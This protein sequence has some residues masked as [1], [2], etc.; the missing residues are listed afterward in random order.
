MR[1]PRREDPAESFGP[2]LIYECLG[3]G[4]MATVHRAKQTGIEGFERPVALKRMLPWLTSDAEFVKSFVREARLAALLRH[5]NIVQTYDLGKVDAIYYIAMELVAGRD[6]RELLRHCH[7][8][9]GPPPAAMTI[10]VLHQVCDALD[11]AHSFR[12]EQGRTLNLV[13]RDISPA[14]IIISEE[15][16]AK[17]VD[18][19]VAKGSTATLATMSGM[20][21]GK[22][23][24]MA[25]EMISGQIDARCD[26]F[27]VGVV[28]WELLTARP[29]FAGGD[30]MEILQRV[31]TWD[32]PAPSSINPAVPR[33]LDA[34]VAMALAKQ[35]QRRFQSAAQMRAGLELAA[36][37]PAMRA[38]SS[39]VAAWTA[40]AFA[41]KQG[42]RPSPPPPVPAPPMAMPM[43]APLAM[44][45]TT[46]PGST[47]APPLAGAIGSAPPMP[48]APVHGQPPAGSAPAT[49][50]GG[51]DSDAITLDDQTN[52][53]SPPVIPARPTPQTIP[54]ARPASGNR[55]PAADVGVITQPGTG[56]VK[57]QAPAGRGRAQAPV[58]NQ[59]A[60][61]IGTA[62]P[63]AV[64]A[65]AA[66][67]RGPSTAPPPP[68]APSTVPPHGAI[69]PSAARTVM[70]DG[71]PPAPAPVPPRAQAPTHLPSMPP[72]AVA[73]PLMAHGYP[74]APPAP[75]A[76]YPGHPQAP[77]PSYPP[78]HGAAHHPPAAAPVNAPPPSTPGVPLVWGA[79]TPGGQPVAAPPMGP[80]TGGP[81]GGFAPG[82]H[83]VGSQGYAAQGG[84]LPLPKPPGGNGLLIT[85]VLLLCAGAA[86]GG[87]FIVQHFS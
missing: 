71:A 3:K 19:G 62:I 21:K 79:G 85:I 53:R 6:L 2:Y 40:W 4:G 46:S 64:A 51:A 55:T 70:F 12:D 80:H 81:V 13:H 25:P 27:A 37:T 18:F 54:S 15:G 45:G 52:P 76:G 32:P 56:T 16:T 43:P 74:A 72:G 24:Y 9:V 60:T 14:N 83:A 82:A 87:Y 31:T 1:E 48:G 42:V 59:H 8:V 33:E 77:T 73:E 11:Y 78:G 57:P 10:H 36:R 38:S 34:W 84:D 26:L 29:L 41:Q 65:A 66:Q 7:N 68:I 5:T 61:M 28:A 49:A 63:A 22:F 39:D 69:A 50:I 17:I 20:L 35:P 58:G 44:P 86:V 30:D 47:T 23:A 75:P 67:H